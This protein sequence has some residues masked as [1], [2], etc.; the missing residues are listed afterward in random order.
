MSEMYKV[1]HGNCLLLLFILFFSKLAY[2]N[3]RLR[4]LLFRKFCTKQNRMDYLN[5]DTFGIF[6]CLAERDEHINTN[7]ALVFNIAI[8]RGFLYHNLPKI[9]MRQ[10]IHITFLIL[11]KIFH[12]HALEKAMTTHSSV[13]AW[14]IPGTGEPG[15]LPSMGSHRVG[16][17]WSDLAAAA[18][19]SIYFGDTLWFLVH[20]CLQ[21][22]SSCLRT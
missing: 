17:N 18:R 5:E 15:G 3:N 11:G 4:P 1:I 21:W 20:N 13:L 9:S 2:I 7:Y 8:G 19:Y 10:M 16:H 6:T 14:R 22:L 12:F